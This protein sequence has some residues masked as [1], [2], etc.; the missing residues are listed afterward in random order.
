MLCSSLLRRVWPLLA[1][2][3]ITLAVTTEGVRADTFNGAA[4][5]SPS[6]AI[7][8]ANFSDVV[9]TPGAVLSV[10]G[11]NPMAVRTDWCPGIR[12]ALTNSDTTNRSSLTSPN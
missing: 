2:L 1:A 9:V 3:L 4:L 5:I 12:W 8:A 10:Q 7:G 6:L 11:G